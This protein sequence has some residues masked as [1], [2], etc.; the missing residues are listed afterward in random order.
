MCF[1]TCANIDG[2]PQEIAVSWFDRASVYHNGR[3]IR[4]R[5]CHDRA[6]HVLVTSGQ[7]NAGI[8]KLSTRDGLDAVC[9]DFPRLERES[10][11]LCAVSMAS[12]EVC[13]T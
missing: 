4:S 2:F 9:N 7:G 5:K 10:H 3:S 11:A 6:R 13:M 12:V 1:V 8:M